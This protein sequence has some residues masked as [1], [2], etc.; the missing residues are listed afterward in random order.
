MELAN[1]YEDTYGKFVWE[2]TRKDLVILEQ[3]IK[4]NNRGQLQASDWKDYVRRRYSEV[5]Q[6][7]PENKDYV[8]SIIRRK[9]QSAADRKRYIDELTAAKAHR[10]KLQEIQAEVKAWK[11]TADS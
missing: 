11:P 10:K 2:N 8:D 7:T 1:D 9:E 3:Q 6:D 5:L 4:E